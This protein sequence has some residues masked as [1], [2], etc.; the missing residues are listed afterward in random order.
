MSIYLY[1]SRINYCNCFIFIN[2]KHK[3]YANSDDGG[4]SS[5]T[6]EHHRQSKRQSFPVAK[7]EESDGISTATIEEKKLEL[8]LAKHPVERQW[9]LLGPYLGQYVAYTGAD[10]AWLLS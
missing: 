8:A 10:T 7:K 3:P 1:I 5:I 9:N 4:V 6:A 2:S